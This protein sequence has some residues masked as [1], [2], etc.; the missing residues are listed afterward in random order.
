MLADGE[1]VPY[2]A[3]LLATGAQPRRPPIPGVDLD[4]VHVLRTLED[5]DALRTVLDAGGR[6]VV[7]GAGWIGCEV[8][9]SARQRGMEVAMVDT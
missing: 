3:L 8:A 9:A 7:V 5:S 2:D 1:R 6:L 4:G